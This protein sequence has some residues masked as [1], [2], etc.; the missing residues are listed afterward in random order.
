MYSHISQM[1]PLYPALSEPLEDIAREVIAA[2]VK[3]EG[4]LA[5]ET[6]DEVRKLLRV[7]NS[8]YS[9]LIEGHS[10]HPVDIERAMRHDYSADQEKRDLPD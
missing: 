2:W 6:L 7:V 8:Y 10:T 5:S 1:E 9:N 4:H 3:L